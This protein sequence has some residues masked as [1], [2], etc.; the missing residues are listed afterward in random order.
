MNFSLNFHL[1]TLYESLISKYEISWATVKKPNGLLQ[2]P[3]H[4]V[5]LRG[6]L[7]LI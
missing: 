7:R 4:L 1:V 5:F 2:E 6:S 3:S